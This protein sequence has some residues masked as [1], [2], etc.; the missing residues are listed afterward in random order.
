VYKENL[1]KHFFG[2]VV[3]MKSPKSHVLS[4]T[5]VF[6]LG[7]HMHLHNVSF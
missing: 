6:D 5:A 7:H 2:H 1:T 3:Q 4:D